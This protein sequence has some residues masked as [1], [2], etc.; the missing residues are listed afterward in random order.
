MLVNRSVVKYRTEIQ[1][2]FTMSTIEGSPKIN[3][4]DSLDEE[5]I[6]SYSEFS[7]VSLVYFAMKESATTEQSSRMTAMDSASKNAGEYN[8]VSYASCF[9]LL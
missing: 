9:I 5:V 4:Y 6:R 3:I 7:L 8:F 2:I 1:P